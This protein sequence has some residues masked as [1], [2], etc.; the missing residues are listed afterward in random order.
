[1]LLPW[2]FSSSQVLN[3]RHHLKPRMFQRVKTGLSCFPSHDARAWDFEVTEFWEVIVVREH[4][5]YFFV[6]LKWWLR[7]FTSNSSR[8]ELPQLPT[9]LHKLW[10]KLLV[11]QV[12]QFLKSWDKYSFLVAFLIFVITVAAAVLFFCLCVKTLAAYLH[13]GWSKPCG[14]PAGIPPH[15]EKRWFVLQL[16]PAS[17]T[18]RALSFH[19]IPWSRMWLRPKPPRV[20]LQLGISPWLLCPSSKYSSRKTF[21]SAI[22]FVKSWL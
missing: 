21:D 7:H 16:S 1:M 4:A 22:A 14:V 5:M 20:I 8:D 10:A 6:W 15:C 12:S 17:L 3:M 13:A 9:S 11:L 18:T 19:P 2:W